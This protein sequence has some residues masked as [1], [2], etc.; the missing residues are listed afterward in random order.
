MN[1]NQHSEHALE[2]TVKDNKVKYA[3][4]DVDMATATRKLQNVIRCTARDLVIAV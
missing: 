1:L 4:R 3:P 2:T